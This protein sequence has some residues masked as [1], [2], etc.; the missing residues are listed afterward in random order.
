MPATSARRSTHPLPAEPCRKPAGSPLT[1][2]QVAA[3]VKFA[4]VNKCRRITVQELKHLAGSDNLAIE[5]TD[6]DSDGKNLYIRLTVK[7]VV[8]G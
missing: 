8:P 7:V 3:S 6:M 5:S 4:E 1:P 2:N